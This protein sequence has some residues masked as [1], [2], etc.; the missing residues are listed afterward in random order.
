M[1]QINALHCFF[2][3]IAWKTFQVSINQQTYGNI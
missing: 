3:E 1:F 2:P